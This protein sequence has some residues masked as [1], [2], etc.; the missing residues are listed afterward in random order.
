MEHLALTFASHEPL[1]EAEHF[2]SQLA[3][4]GVPV[5]LALHLPEQFAWHCALQLPWA[6]PPL[7]LPEH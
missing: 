7:A 5:Q 1:H 4:G 6:L 3:D 2:A